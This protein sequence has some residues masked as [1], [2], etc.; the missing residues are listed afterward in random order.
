[1]GFIGQRLGLGAGSGPLYISSISCRV[2]FSFGSA[3]S[4]WYRVSRVSLLIRSKMDRLAVYEDKGRN[5]TRTS[6]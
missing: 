5:R 4:V 6:S 3:S 2:T 1:M